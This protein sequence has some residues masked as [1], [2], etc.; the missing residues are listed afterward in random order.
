MPEPTSLR[1][2]HALGRGLRLI[3]EAIDGEPGRAWQVEQEVARR[4]RVR[5]IE[6][7]HL[8]VGSIPFESGA[9]NEPIAGLPVPLRAHLRGPQLGTLRE[10][11]FF[12][13]GEG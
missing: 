13:K 9:R 8:A 12:A 2:T 10:P 3:G 4:L 5:G 1:L 7:L 6:D 11:A